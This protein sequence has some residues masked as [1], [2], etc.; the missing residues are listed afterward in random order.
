MRGAVFAG[1]QD[2]QGGELVILRDITQEKK[3]ARN[4]EVLQRISTSLPNYPDLEELLDYISNEV[5]SL[6]NTDGVLVILLDE[7]R[8]EFYFKGAAYSD[9]STQ[10]KVKEFR[11][12]SDKGLAGKVVRTG[13]PVVVQD[14]SKDPDFYPFMD[15]QLG[16]STKNIVEVPLRTSDR[17]IGILCALNK[18]GGLLIKATWSY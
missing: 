8:Q 5:K 6:M 11:F 16:Y 15:K 9:K 4:N 2:S 17:V 13:E 7:E 3:M 12:P 14:T 10:R 1:D 18:K